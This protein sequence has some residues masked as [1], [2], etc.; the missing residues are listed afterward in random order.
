MA[1]NPQLGSTFKPVPM[2]TEEERTLA[3]R[4]IRRRLTEPA[5]ADRVLEALFAPTSELEKDIAKDRVRRRRA[6][7]KA[8]KEAA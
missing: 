4:L 2:I 3:T 5:D 8:P 7:K 6:A 1:V